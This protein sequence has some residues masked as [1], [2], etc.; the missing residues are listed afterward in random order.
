MYLF[1]KH[2]KKL[3]SD[4]HTPTINFQDDIPQKIYH[5]EGGICIDCGAGTAEKRDLFHC[6][7]YGRLACLRL[8][9][10]K[11]FYSEED[12]IIT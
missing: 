12:Y 7:C 9:D 6:F 4:G 2:Y 1:V 3:L 10:M 11:E 8:D 5:R